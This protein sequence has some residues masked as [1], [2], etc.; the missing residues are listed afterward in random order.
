MVISKSATPLA[1]NQQYSYCFLPL[2]K[3]IKASLGFKIKINISV[4]FYQIKHALIINGSNERPTDIVWDC[5][6][7][8]LQMAVLNSKA[9][10][11]IEYN[12]SNRFP[13]ISI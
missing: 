6:I 3:S 9:Q 10:V 12:L 4:T 2:F 11:R 7:L 5:A 13:I 1:N 8:I